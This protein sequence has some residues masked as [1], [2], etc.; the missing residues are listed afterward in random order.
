M[1]GIEDEVWG[2]GPS[3]SGGGGG[4]SR[5]RT[6]PSGGSNDESQKAFNRRLRMLSDAGAGALFQLDN[7][8][9]LDLI[10]NTDI[11]DTEMLE[12]FYGAL[13][14]SHKSTAIEYLEG[15]KKESQRFFWNSL[16]ELTKNELGAFGYEVPEKDKIDWYN[17]WDW[18]DYFDEKV[19]S[20]FRKAGINPLN[21]IDMITKPKA[22]FGASAKSVAKAPWILATGPMSLV[23][24][25]GSWVPRKTIEL[26]HE[27]FKQGQRNLRGMALGLQDMEP[28][29]PDTNHYMHLWHHMKQ[30]AK[31]FA[32]IIKYREN[33]KYAET[34]WTDTV[35]A[36]IKDHLSDH[37]K[38]DPKDVDRLYEQLIYTFRYGD[39]SEGIF[40]YYLDENGGDQILARQQ[41]EKWLSSG[42]LVSSGWEH[43]QKLA[44]GNVVSYGG[45]HKEAIEELTLQIPPFFGGARRDNFQVQVLGWNLFEFEGLEQ[46]RPDAFAGYQTQVYDEESKEWIQ[47]DKIIRGPEFYDGRDEA[48]SHAGGYTRLANGA[49]VFFE[50]LGSIAFDPTNIGLSAIGRIR[51]ARSAI[52]MS[53]K[54]RL[55]SYASM[56]ESE[57][58]AVSAIRALDDLEAA[59]DVGVPLGEAVAEAGMFSRL[60]KGIFNGTDGSRSSL[61]SILK[62]W[63]EKHGDSYFKNTSWW[64]KEELRSEGR[65]VDQIVT[66]FQRHEVWEAEQMRRHALGLPAW[67]TASPLVE[68]VRQDA[69]F[70]TVI[71][72]MEAWHKARKGAVGT[73]DFRITQVIDDAGNVI[74][75]DKLYVDPSDINAPVRK[76]GLD[77]WDGWWDFLA[78]EAG[79]YTLSVGLNQ[80]H[81]TAMFYPRLSWAGIL[82]NRT[83]INARTFMGWGDSLQGLR[84]SVWVDSVMRHEAIGQRLVGDVVWGQ[85]QASKDASTAVKALTKDEIWSAAVRPKYFEEHASTLGKNWGLSTGEI[86]DLQALI[87]KRRTEINERLYD[88][89]NSVVVKGDDIDDYIKANKDSFH[90]LQNPETVQA[91]KDNW[92]HIDEFWQAHISNHGVPRFSESGQLIFPQNWWRNWGRQGKAFAERRRR[93]LLTSPGSV[94]SEHLLRFPNEVTKTTT[95]TWDELYQSGIDIGK[96]RHNLNSSKITT[97]NELM[98]LLDDMGLKFVAEEL[99]VSVKTLKDFI[100]KDLHLYYAE[101]KM[102][103]A[104]GKLTDFGL[105]VAYQ[106]MYKPM[107]W[108]SF[109]FKKAPTKGTLDVGVYP[110]RSIEAWQKNIDQLAELKGL[111]DMGALANMPTT[112]IDAYLTRFM[113]GTEGVR[114]NVVNEFLY[115]VMARSGGFAYGRKKALDIFREYASA[116]H[117]AYSNIGQDLFLGK[118]G[119]TVGAVIPAEAHAAQL[120]HLKLIPNWR[121]VGRMTQHMGLLRHLGYKFGIAQLDLFFQRFWRPKVLM[122][123]GVAPRNF[124]DETIQM[125]LRHG[126]GHQVDTRLAITAAGR[127]IKR[128]AYG[129]PVGTKVGDVLWTEQQIKMGDRQ[130]MLRKAAGVEPVAS[131]NLSLLKF[132]SILLRK[133]LDTFQLGN[134]ALYKKAQR[135]AQLRAGEKW[136][137]KPDWEKND[138]IDGELIKLLP[139]GENSTFVSRALLHVQFL[140]EWKLRRS[141]LPESSIII[142]SSPF[143]PSRS[144][145][146]TAANKMLEKRGVSGEIQK[147]GVRHALNNPVVMESVTEDLMRPLAP[148]MDEVAG[149]DLV[150]RNGGEIDIRN[151]RYRL[152]MDPKRVETRFYNS[153]NNPQEKLDG[154]MQQLHWLKDE[155]AAVDMGVE[156]AHHIDEPLNNW[157]KNIVPPDYV[158]PWRKTGKPKPSDSFV[159]PPHISDIDVKSVETG[160]ESTIVPASDPLKNI[161]AKV[162]IHLDFGV[163][164]RQYKSILFGHKNITKGPNAVALETLGYH[165][166]TF[167]E[168]LSELNLTAGHSSVP[169][170]FLNLINAERAKMGMAPKKVGDVLEQAE[171]FYLYSFEREVAKARLQHYE[172]TVTDVDLVKANEVALNQLGIGKSAAL[173]DKVPLAHPVIRIISGG[174][175]GAD[176]AGLRAG[177][178]LQIETGGF[179]P[180]DEK[181]KLSASRKKTKYGKPPQD[182]EMRELGLVA[183]EGEIPAQGDSSAWAEFYLKRTHANIDAADGTVIFTQKDLPKTLDGRGVTGTQ[184]TIDYAKGKEDHVHKIF[185][186][187]KF[188]AQHKKELLQWLKRNN[189]KTLN[190]AGPRQHVIEAKWI[191]K[192][193]IMLGGKFGEG[194]VLKAA[195]HVKSETLFDAVVNGERTALIA[196]KST[197]VASETIRGMERDPDLATGVNPLIEKGYKSGEAKI[198]PIDLQPGLLERFG[199]GQL[200]T[201]Q[202]GKDKVLARVTSK[203]PADSYISRE[204]AKKLGYEYDTRT[205]DWAELTESHTVIEFELIA[206]DVAKT[207][208]S[209][210]SEVERFL[211]DALAGGART[212]QPPAPDLTPAKQS[213]LRKNLETIESLGGQLDYYPQSIQDITFKNV[214][215][216]V[217]W[218]SP[219]G[220][221]KPYVT[222][223]GDVGTDYYYT[224][225]HYHVVDEGKPVGTIIRS[226]KKGKTTHVYIQGGWNPV[227]QDI[228][229]QVEGITGYEF[230][231]VI[232]Q[233]YSSGNIDLGFHWDKETGKWPLEPEAIIASV[234]LGASRDFVFR[235]RHYEVGPAKQTFPMYFDYGQR[236][237][238]GKASNIKSATTFEAIKAGERTATTRKSGTV[239][240][241][242]GDIVAFTKDEEKIYARVTKV[243]KTSET[244]PKQW[245]KLE[246]YSAE[247]ATKNWTKGKKYGVGHTQIVFEYL[248]K[249]PASKRVE[250]DW[251]QPRVK[252]HVPFALSDKD[253]FLMREGTQDAWEHSLIKGKGH[254][255]P[256]INLTFRRRNPAL[257]KKKRGASATPFRGEELPARTISEVKKMTPELLKANKDK[258]YLFGDNLKRTGK[259]GQSIIRDEPNA[260]GIPTKKSARVFWTDDTYD[261]NT[262]AIDKAFDS[263]P[264]GEIVIP[265]DGLGTGRAKLKENAPETFKYLESKLKELKESGKQSVVSP[266]A[267]F[268]PAPPKPPAFE[269]PQPPPPPDPSYGAA[270]Q[271]YDK[272]T[273]LGIRQHLRDIYFDPP[274]VGEELQRVEELIKKIKRTSGLS[275]QDE[276]FV[277]GLFK[278]EAGNSLVN[279]KG[280]AWLINR[281]IDPDA[282]SGGRNLAPIL[283]RQL[284]KGKAEFSS[285]AG[286]DRLY[287]L[288]ASD[289]RHGVM[290]PV[291]PGE[292]EVFLPQINGDAALHLGYIFDSPNGPMVIELKKAL[293]GFLAKELGDEKL[294]T[295]VLYTLDP[296]RNPHGTMRANAWLER[297]IPNGG[298]LLGQLQSNNPIS[299]QPG[300]FI[301]LG[302]HTGIQQQ[303]VVA[304][305]GSHNSKHAQSIARA[306]EQWNEWIYQT[307]AQASQNVLDNVL[308]PTG[309]FMTLPL[310]RRKYSSNEYNANQ[311]FGRDWGSSQAINVPRQGQGQDVS[312]PPSVFISGEKWADKKDVPLGWVEKRDD[313]V[314]TGE[315]VPEDVTPSNP[316]E[317]TG[318][319]G[320]ETELEAQNIR[321]PEVPSSPARL[322]SSVDRRE[323]IEEEIINL[324]DSLFSLPN[325]SVVTYAFSPTA[326][327]GR[328][329]EDLPYYDQFGFTLDRLV[330]I[331]NEHGKSTTST[332]ADLEREIWE[333]L[334]DLPAAH[335]IPKE[336]KDLPFIGRVGGP[337][338]EG[339]RRIFTEFEATALVPN[340]V[341]R[342]NPIGDIA[343]FDPDILAPWR[344]PYEEMQWIHGENPTFRVGDT[345]EEL[346]GKEIVWKEEEFLNYARPD[347]QFFPGAGL[348]KTKPQQM[349]TPREGGKAEIDD[350]LFKADLKDIEFYLINRISGIPDSKIAEFLAWRKQQVNEHMNSVDYAWPF[351]RNPQ[352]REGNVTDYVEDW[353]TILRNPDPQE[354][355]TAFAETAKELEARGIPIDPTAKERTATKTARIVKSKLKEIQHSETP[356]SLWTWDVERGTGVRPQDIGGFHKG[357]SILGV[358]PRGVNPNTTETVMDSHNMM[359]VWRHK[360]TKEIKI[361]PD[362]AYNP[363]TKE[364][365]IPAGFTPKD[366]EL[367]ESFEMGSNNMDNFVEKQS[368]VI[369]N[370]MNHLLTTQDRIGSTAGAELNHPMLLELTDTPA[371]ETI[372]ETRLYPHVNDALL[373]ER[374]LNTMPAMAPKKGH[375]GRIMSAIKHIEKAFFGGYMHPVIKGGI[376][377]PMFLWYFSETYASKGKFVTE[378]Y[379]HSPSAFKPLEKT[380]MEEPPKWLMP[381][382][383]SPH[384]KIADNGVQQFDIPELRPLID[385]L[386]N[387]RKADDMASI[388]AGLIDDWRAGVKDKDVLLKQI[389]DLPKGQLRIK[390]DYMLPD[391]TNLK[392]LHA[393]NRGYREGAIQD[394]LMNRLHYDVDTI[395]DSKGIFYRVFPGNEEFFFHL[396]ETSTKEKWDLTTRNI[397]EWISQQASSYHAHVDFSALDAAK[398]MSHFVDNHAKR[399][400]FQEMVGSAIPFHFAHYQFL[401]RWVKTV[402]HNPA[403]IPRLNWLLFAAQQTGYRYEDERTG[404]VRIKIPFVETGVGIFLELMNDIPIIQ[405]FLGSRFISV[406]EDGVG[407]PE[408]YILPGY[409]PDNLLELQIGPILGI[410]L[411]TA[412]HI[413][414]PQMLDE[415]LFGIGEN[416]V[417]NRT[418]DEPLV[419]SIFGQLIP[420]TFLKPFAVMMNTIGGSDI[421]DMYSKA[422]MDALMILGMKGML[423]DQIDIAGRPGEAVFTQNWSNAIEHIAK[424]KM[425]MDFVTW[426][427]VGTSGQS[428]SLSTGEPWTWNAFM[429]K[430]IDMGMPHPEAFE[431]MLEETK[432]EFD[433]NFELTY[434]GLSKDD[435]FYWDEWNREI[436]KIGTTTVG[437]TEKA[438]IAE[439]P[440]TKASWEFI[441]EHGDWIMRSPLVHSFFIYKGVTEEETTFHRFAYDWALAGGLRRERTNEEIQVAIMSVAPSVAYYEQKEAHLRQLNVFRKAR[442]EKRINNIKPDVSWEDMIMQEEERWDAWDQNYKDRYPIWAEDTFGLDSQRKRSETIEE[443]R[444]LFT[445]DN[446]DEIPDDIPNRDDILKGMKIIVNLDDFLSEHAGLRGNNNN[447]VSW[448]SVRNNRMLDSYNTFRGL[449]A[450]RPWLNT[451]FYNLFMPFIGEDWVIK[452]E[453]GTLDLGAK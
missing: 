215:D 149:T 109:W 240:V 182:A 369:Q 308:N 152:E 200:I 338:H 189:I 97:P 269:P 39:L 349:P 83:L 359:H 367:I 424:T 43:A 14:D 255:G 172:Q 251:D 348:Y 46:K 362:T 420:T 392:G 220:T 371:G 243:H 283:G 426:Q 246:G 438:T 107:Q 96:M 267:G 13:D 343:Q 233:K 384:H 261:A 421:A 55:E 272:V 63:A 129:Q 153:I 223:L 252:K 357:I 394:A 122:K 4:V 40:R 16:P 203:K 168:G 45:V 213:D 259:S 437:T 314:P 99:R 330:R 276:K 5:R 419:D 188:T 79:F 136:D 275:T 100:K 76:P 123:L 166:R 37:G 185:E 441:Q 248:P 310:V 18:K 54:A 44:S 364:L 298:S 85:L 102:Y 163:L 208:A 339:V 401:S 70:E 10:M 86:D 280:L 245:A 448:T 449:V 135:N 126:F 64:R 412:S 139:G 370:E 368:R 171:P 150:V 82:R 404:Q 294:A 81:P 23:G 440:S 263:I 190:V 325:N 385:S 316:F 77:E 51:N 450:G 52:R 141:L 69:R 20:E 430:G 418:Y 167:V 253:V 156:L 277:R 324:A 176:I 58:E 59:L 376:R 72:L 204:L 270:Q 408:R 333:V 25:I 11:S 228:K 22:F 143:D 47:G 80:R 210:E 6:N 396:K 145:K 144:A 407:F 132:P 347:E 400:F 225:F 73:Q 236:G 301:P 403:A 295:E 104:A 148:Y 433:A 29:P 91:I 355:P 53:T 127:V 71:Q 202:R 21:P 322:S 242:K 26:V 119:L 226:K 373:P 345:V 103:N 425:V 206:E 249:P 398:R 161:E 90:A 232:V 375:G 134:K 434:P 151:V 106:T 304:L 184:R 320:L 48:L 211:I 326:S 334:G 356:R 293:K 3:R 289:G 439:L 451:L 332:F 186:T 116:P 342:A 352:A 288:M 154:A 305:A 230:D 193:P 173:S 133:T 60:T 262:K 2:S 120:T 414:G 315:W 164:A 405:K 453:E 389:F 224:G 67:D 197:E 12:G 416:L 35:I 402:E 257:Q 238:L 169:E 328:W 42:I 17:P 31:P 300:S 138:L 33:T 239:G 209:F 284:D 303:T 84:G 114:M 9:I 108:A 49:G 447:G 329:K 219:F 146:I 281:R 74:K 278:H 395:F 302:R 201:I 61:K 241:K 125:G 94:E 297:S 112:V 287:S 15:M 221:H 350:A 372:S 387:E 271:A 65:K 162:E 360:R 344:I 399:S 130:A 340:K 423:P 191:P 397:M 217:E 56:V 415:G 128:D 19:G 194:K 205:Q 89:Y 444:R 180:I 250:Y 410:P 446:L 317:S 95:K 309:P 391:G 274:A 258:V 264:E 311:M 318:I 312:R 292:I 282:L 124:F 353:K 445:Y 321:F 337:K 443:M 57:R 341:L 331:I 393:L 427:L 101:N 428:E 165:P 379:Q 174:Q 187:D 254:E 306:I 268:T 429:Q 157:F 411:T 36:G 256:R 323:Y 413:I 286:K 115:D 183:I 422:E 266:P 247:E 290:S 417:M 299:N 28:A 8:V 27:G 374:V 159:K 218:S 50:I 75:Q 7:D 229:N 98:T 436:T 244:N 307:G 354:Y 41:M 93:G 319:P 110:G 383:L 87:I 34:T 234:N 181:G 260:H 335:R 388:F 137:N 222:V 431:Y 390:N 366:Y 296:V 177:R 365:N 142:R 38:T 380:L 214:D 361:L 179:A 273:E 358:N 113:F 212:Y 406:F 231:V 196:P 32:G 24:A 409:D 155:P 66:A 140:A 207:G 131:H 118:S 199:E 216:V 285:I 198:L 227:I 442:D 105:A 378:F 30:F 435:P 279:S 170:T 452:L 111:V 327:Y 147:E 178:A 381:S 195:D 121:E 265:K 1:S 160:V 336:Q 235:P 68:L 386:R 78:E 291:L 192:S 117:H 377:E 351:Y 382:R 432:K 62:P 313:G 92:V 363:V 88:M 237:A 158:P 175:S 346:A